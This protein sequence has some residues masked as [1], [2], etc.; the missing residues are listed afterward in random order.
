MTTWLAAIQ[1]TMSRL[2]RSMGLP[3]SIGILGL[4]RMCPILA[5]L[6]LLLLVAV[7]VMVLG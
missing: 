3:D 4:I 6:S 1:Q 7:G 5:F 2:K